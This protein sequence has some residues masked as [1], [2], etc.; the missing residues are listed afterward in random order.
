MILRTGIAQ[1]HDLVRIRKRYRPN[2][3]LVVMTLTYMQ[4]TPKIAHSHSSTVTNEA[5]E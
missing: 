5:L 2:E 1:G 3:V 4:S